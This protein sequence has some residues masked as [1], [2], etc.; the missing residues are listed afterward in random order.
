MDARRVSRPVTKSKKKPVYRAV[1]PSVPEYPGLRTNASIRTTVIPYMLKS[2]ARPHRPVHKTRALLSTHIHMASDTAIPRVLS[3][4]SHVVHG[5]V[6]G[7]PTRNGP[8]HGSAY[9]RPRRA[10]NVPS[11]R[12]KDWAS[13]WT[14]STACSSQTTPV[15][16]RLGSRLGIVLTT[17]W[18]RLSEIQGDCFRWETLARSIRWTRSKRH[19]TLF[20]LA[21]GVG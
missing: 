5:Y 18:C 11:L 7:H 15:M 14:P 16:R 12:Y 6:V 1:Y 8:P 3:I 13:R 20:S 10:V 9:S 21:N 17:R 4:Q 19:Q 2:L